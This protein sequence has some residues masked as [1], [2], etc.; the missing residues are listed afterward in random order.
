MRSVGELQLKLRISGGLRGNRLL[1]LFPADLKQPEQKIFSH[2]PCYYLNIVINTWNF[3]RQVLHFYTLS[4]QTLQVL[5]NI[6][7]KSFLKV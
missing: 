7:V 6:H 2:V 4:G 3:T 5:L 1:R